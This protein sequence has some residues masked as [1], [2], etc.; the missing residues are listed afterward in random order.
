M[1]LDK[2]KARKA[3]EERKVNWAHSLRQPSFTA[4]ME[5]ESHLT[6]NIVRKERFLQKHLVKDGAQTKPDYSLIFGRSKIP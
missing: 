1:F 3:A 2:L 5:E 4:V 6:S